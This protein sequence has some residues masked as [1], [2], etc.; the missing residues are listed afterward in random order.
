M[1]K[2]APAV[3][4]KNPA[5]TG[6]KKHIVNPDNERQRDEFETIAEALIRAK[7][8][9][10]IE[11]KHRKER[12]EVDVPPLALK[13]GLNVTLRAHEGF[14]PILVLDKAYKDKD[15]ALFKL[16]E[17]KLQFEQLGFVLDPLTTGFD[18]QS[19]VHLGEAAHCVFKQC[20]ITLKAQADVQLN[21][22]TLVDLNQ[23]MKMDTTP[24]P[25]RVDFQDCF[26]RGRGDLVSLR[27]SR[28]LNV[29]MKNSLVVLDGSLLD[30]MANDKPNRQQ[31]GVRWK[32][33]RTSAFTTDSIFALRSRTNNGLAKTE[34]DVRSCLLVSLR[35]ERPIV[36]LDMKTGE[37]DHYLKWTGE[38][39]FFANFDK[40]NV[41]VWQ[42]LFGGAKTEFGKIG[43]PKLTEKNMQALWDA[44]PDWLKPTD[45]I[46]VERIQNV[47]IPAEIESK[48]LQPLVDTEEP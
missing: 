25:A 48:L 14:Q 2:A 43:M 40:D 32:M 13:P 36:F 10:I 11:I 19:V 31:D 47:G 33:E 17:G 1:P 23:M 35:P 22:A 8:G 21:V 18:S 27:G 39:N 44:D 4:V 16:V 5:P 26:I 29:D 12:R 7:T 28:V 6:P 24:P 30:V 15:S 41:D 3:L 20:V 34:A 45:P 9:D 46:E 42:S 38:Q 37:L